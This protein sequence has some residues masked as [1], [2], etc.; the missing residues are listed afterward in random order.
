MIEVNFTV[1][2][3]CAAF[4][5][6]R[7]MGVL[8]KSIQHGDGNLIGTIGEEVVRYTFGGEDKSTR[9]YDLIINGKKVDVKSKGR[10]VTPQQNYLCSIPKYQDFQECDWYIF[11]SVSIPL[12][13]AWVVGHIKKDMFWKDSVFRKKGEIDPDDA[14]YP[15]RDDCN[16]IKICQLNKFKQE[17]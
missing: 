15:F 2:M 3:L 12:R 14:K 6:A 5:K 10:N 9:D 11:T 17:K 7:N 4:I 16:T 1:D 13:K 8:H